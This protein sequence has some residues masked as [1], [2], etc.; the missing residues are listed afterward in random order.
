MHGVWVIIDYKCGDTIQK[1]APPREV[2]NNV[3]M[4]T[5]RK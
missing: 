2:F 3:Q 4:N 1:P 5:A